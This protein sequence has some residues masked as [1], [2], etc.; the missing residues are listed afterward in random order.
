[1]SF[2][3]HLPPKESNSWAHHWYQSIS[4]S[5]AGLEET[6]LQRVSISYVAERR[7]GDSP[8]AFSKMMERKTNKANLCERGMPAVAAAVS[9]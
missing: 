9:E 1:M 6:P 3:T 5:C 7:P 2:S 4:T 8:S